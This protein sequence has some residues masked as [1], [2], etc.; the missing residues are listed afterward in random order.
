MQGAL[1]QFLDQRRTLL[2][3]GAM[4]T[5][6][7]RRGVATGLPLWSASALFSNPD[8]VLAIHREYLLAGADIITTNTF[9]TTRRTF[10][11]AG[12]PDR[13]RELV[14]KACALAR[15]ARM[16]VPG[17][18]VLI[19]GSVA[20]LEDCYRPDLVP[21][22]AELREEHTELVLRLV[23]EG[24]DCILL[25]TMGTIRETQAAYTAAR[26]AGMDVIVSFLCGSDGTLYGGESL[27][28][29]IIQLSELEPTLFSINCLPA[30]DAAQVLH[31]LHSMTHLPIGVYA[32]TGVAGK[33]REDQ[34]LVISV[35]PD[36]YGR[37][38]GEW[39]RAGATMVGGCCGTTPDHIRACAETISL[40]TETTDD[41]STTRPYD[42]A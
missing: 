6:L 14:T 38:A 33:E 23:D 13:S 25:E 22:P 40:V 2:L 26:E 30:A 16:T 24:V 10:R 20:P 18:D 15:E 17:R 39:I 36:A 1:S 12:L 28:E 31:L 21:S 34:E 11:N 32:N 29:A 27:E 5:E 8:A 42:P 37:L 3:D 4:G 7:H 9:R 35:P 19:A 41:R